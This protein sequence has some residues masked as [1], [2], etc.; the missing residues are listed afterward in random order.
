[1]IGDKHLSPLTHLTGPSMSFAKHLAWLL[2]LRC[3]KAVLSC[4]PLN[5]TLLTEA[6]RNLGAHDRSHSQKVE[7]LAS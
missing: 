4:K 2:H 3:F 5:V 7:G 1:M 6:L